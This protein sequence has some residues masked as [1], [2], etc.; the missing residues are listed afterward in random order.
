M[1]WAT[2]SG[3]GKV[4]Q[5]VNALLSTTAASTSGSYAD[6]GL[7]AT[8]TPS[9]ATSKV[10]IIAS[11]CGLQATGGLSTY[12]SLRLVRTS[13]QLIE[14][15]NRYGL[16]SEAAHQ[17]EVGGS[18]CN[19]LDNPATTSATTYKIQFNRG[20]GSGTVRVCSDNITSTITLLEI[21]V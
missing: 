6:T 4:L 12:G 21:G 3:G 18:S 20:A 11:V 17:N 5:V 13:T 19:Y 14:F 1:K 16:T 9:S 10:L 2:P 7:T 15:E 8:I